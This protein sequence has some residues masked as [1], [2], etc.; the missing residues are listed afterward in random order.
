[1]SDLHEVLEQK[2]K[3][4]AFLKENEIK[5]MC[6]NRFASKVQYNIL[7]GDYR[8]LYKMQSTIG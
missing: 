2:N 3:E 8:G 4:I 7:N 5:L 6:E 1:M